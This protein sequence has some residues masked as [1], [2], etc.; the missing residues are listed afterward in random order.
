M[1]EPENIQVNHLNIKLIK[2][3]QQ[4]FDFLTKQYNTI[5]SYLQNLTYQNC[6]NNNIMY[7]IIMIGIFHKTIY[8]A[9]VIM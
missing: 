1:Q 9:L 6:N 5:Q 3:K 4:S 7:I 8:L 2:E